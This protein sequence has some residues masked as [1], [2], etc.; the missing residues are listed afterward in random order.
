MKPIDPVG[1]NPS[2]GTSAGSTKAKRPKSSVHSRKKTDDAGTTRIGLPHLP[3]LTK[4]QMEQEGWAGIMAQVTSVPAVVVPGHLRDEV[5]ILSAEMY[6]L[7]VRLATGDSTGEIASD[8]IEKAL[9]LARVQAKWDDRLAVL[10]DGKVLETVV[11]SPPR[12]GKIK[13]GPV[14]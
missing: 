4:A 8:E 12:Q 2:I 7:L 1:R 5:V 11:N 3:S 13:P 9:L 14:F 10:K 6:E